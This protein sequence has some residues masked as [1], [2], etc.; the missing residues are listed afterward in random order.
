MSDQ[1]RI[2]KINFRH[3]IPIPIY[4]GRNIMN[5]VFFLP[6]KSK[7]NWNVARTLAEFDLIPCITNIIAVETHNDRI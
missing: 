2:I 4:L 6:Y 3:H 5:F 1:V 7:L